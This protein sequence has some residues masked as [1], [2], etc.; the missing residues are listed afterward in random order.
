MYGTRVEVPDLVHFGTWVGGDMDGN[1]NVGADTM[2]EALDA[3]RA[4]ALEQYRRD[5]RALAEVLTQTLG[6]IGVDA[7]VLERIGTY[8]RQWPGQVAVFKPRWADMPYRLLLE[9]IGARLLATGDGDPRGYAGVDE[10]IADLVL[11]DDSLAAHRGNHAGR[12]ALQRVLRRARAF[13]FHLAALDLRQDSAVH[14]DALAGGESAAATLAVFAEAQALRR[15]HGP[16]AIG[17]Y[18]ISMARSAADAL[19]VLTLARRGGCVEDD[20][21]PLDVAPLFETVADLEAAP[22]V[23]R[24]LFEDPVYRA[25]L[26]ARGDRQVVML[27]YSDS[28][29]RPGARCWPRRRVRSM[30]PC[31]RPSRAK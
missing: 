25:H 20:R 7:A 27:G 14:A 21:V 3:Q 26:Q 13:G 22:A 29:A 31:A 15:S 16:G 30:A 9:L 17:L 10:F 4:L 2:R 8:S 23:M 5:V 19:A 6:R 18:I 1:P 24:E 28:A 11:V 12:F